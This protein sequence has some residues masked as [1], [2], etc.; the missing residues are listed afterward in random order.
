M[1][2]KIVLAVDD[3]PLN[4]EIISATL[5][6]AAVDLRFAAG[7]IEAL[8]VIEQLGSRL[9]LVILDRMMPVVDGMDV[10]RRIKSQGGWACVPVVMQTA[11]ATPHEV[12]EGLRAGAYYYLT[13][14]YSPEALKAIV[15]AALED[16][17]RKKLLEGGERFGGLR[18]LQR[19][20]FSVRTLDEA[21]AL[22]EMLASLCPDPSAAWTGLRELLANAVE[23]GNLCISYAEKA[24]L[25][26]EERWR[27]EVD[28]RA[29]LPEYA[30][31]R[32]EVTFEQG[33]RELRFIVADE[34]AGFAWRKYLTFD[35][36]RAFDPNGRG[37]ALARALCFHDLHYEG[38]GNVAVATIDLDLIEQRRE[39]S[40][41]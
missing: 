23:H 29:E 14:P 24:R 15:L 5:E 1:T 30:S 4:L 36:E 8:T 12:E 7:G 3:D 27:E 11:A 26:R 21:D 17:Q 41:A 39:E 33:P 37:I 40:G 35:A 31:R 32:V 28:R 25:K 22:A 13:K 34:G 6:D 9:D 10:L 38:S 19:G 18:A 20:T 2:R 16:R